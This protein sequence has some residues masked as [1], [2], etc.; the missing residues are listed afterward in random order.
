MRLRPAYHLVFRKLSIDSF[1]TCT[2]SANH[3][4]QYSCGGGHGCHFE[5]ERA[6]TPARYVRGYTIAKFR[7][8]LK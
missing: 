4:T 7:R 3:Q 8:L 2:S 5:S 6:A 1:V